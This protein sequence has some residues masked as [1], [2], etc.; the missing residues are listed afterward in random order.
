V[1]KAESK[2]HKCRIW[3]HFHSIFTKFISLESW[4]HLEHPQK[5]RSLVEYI[6]LSGSYLYSNSI[7]AIAY[8]R[9]QYLTKVA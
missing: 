6:E 9:E 3:I 4:Y 1:K 2:E 8:T 7:E 5:Q